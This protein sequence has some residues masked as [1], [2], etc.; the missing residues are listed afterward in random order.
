MGNSLTWYR[1]DPKVMEN[2]DEL[3]QS[4]IVEQEKLKS[5]LIVHDT[6]EWQADRSLNLVGGLDLSFFKDDQTK[7]FCTLVILSV[8]DLKVVYE[9]TCQVE[10]TFPYLAGFLAFRESQPCLEAFNR[11]VRDRP[12]LRP[13]VILFDGNGILHPRGLGLASHFGVL[14]GVPTIGVAKNLYQMGCVVRDSQHAERSRS[15]EQAGS[16]FLIRDET[17][18]NLAAVML[19]LEKKIY[20][21]PSGRPMRKRGCLKLTFA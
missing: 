14:A 15:L 16:W 18:K 12:E 17:G 2:L 20:K 5:H 7:A 11:L 1:M 13:Q 10:L 8:P 3:K 9:D 21:L 19:T 4:W 6:E